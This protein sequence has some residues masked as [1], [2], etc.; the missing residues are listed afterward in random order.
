[1]LVGSPLQQ[2][3]GIQN[4]VLC[5]TMPCHTQLAPCKKRDEIMCLPSLLFAVCTHWTRQ[6]CS[7]IASPKLNVTVAPSVCSGKVYSEAAG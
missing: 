4:L 5:D 7:L 2:E 6:G 3:L 1:M